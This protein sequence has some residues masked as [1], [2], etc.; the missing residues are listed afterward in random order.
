VKAA[1]ERPGLVPKNR[2]EK[3]PLKS[4]VGKSVALVRC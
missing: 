1:H 4:Y 3:S 2:H